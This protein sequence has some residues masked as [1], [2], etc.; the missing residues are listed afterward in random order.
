MILKEKLPFINKNVLE[1]IHKDVGRSFPESM[2]PK[3]KLT[4][5]HAAS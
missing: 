5:Y 1:Q 3:K 4:I 2:F